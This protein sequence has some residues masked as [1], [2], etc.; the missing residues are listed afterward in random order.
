MSTAKK[1]SMREASL[2]KTPRLIS[3]PGSISH[4]EKTDTGLHFR[5]VIENADGVPFHLIFGSGIGEGYYM[6]VGEGIEQLTGIPADRFT[7]KNFYNMVEKTIPLSNDIPANP[8]IS[9]EKFINGEIKKYKA[10]I[11]IRLETGERKWIRDSSLPLIDDETG[12]VIG[13]YGILFEIVS[14]KQ[15]AQV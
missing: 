11:L 3:S 8:I 14:E 7:E 5:K 4:E 9:R 1:N 2:L 13:S 12:R 15:A 10:E 6:S